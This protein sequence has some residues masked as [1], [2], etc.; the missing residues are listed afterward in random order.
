MIVPTIKEGGVDTVY[1]M[2]CFPI[3]I[4]VLPSEEIRL[5]SFACIQAL[6]PIANA[7]KP[8]LQPPITT[9]AA[10]LSYRDRLQSFAPDVTFLMTLYLN[11]STTP[12]TIAE[13]AQA[14]IVGLKAYPVGVTT[15][16]EAGV[17][18]FRSYYPVFEAMQAHD[19]VLNL[20]GE[21]PSTPSP[22][23]LIAGSGDAVT[24]LNAETM[25]LPTLH[26]LHADF[27]GEQTVAGTE[28]RLN[29]H[30]DARRKGLRIVLEH[31]TTREALDAVRTCGPTV[32]G[33][34]TAHHLWMSVDDWCGDA[35]NFCKPVAKTP[36]DRV[37]LLRAVV[38]GGAG[39]FFF[40]KQI[41]AVAVHNAMI[42]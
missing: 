23:F 28:I 4:F 7:F 8:N 21:V 14:G 36:A 12:T 24:V 20:H 40:G 17:L 42:W 39:K 3:L 11:K 31:C 15:N 10:A 13:A 41:A 25:F 27:P 19:L 33:S 18:D 9:V 5:L 2:V 6:F 1:V 30:A 37:A 29:N 38:E 16:S 32:A 22:D 26:K 34:I 35:F